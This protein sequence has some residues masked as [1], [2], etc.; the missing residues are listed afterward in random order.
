MSRNSS[1]VVFGSIIAVGATVGFLLKDPA[2]RKPHYVSAKTRIVVTFKDQKFTFTCEDESISPRGSP[3]VEVNFNGTI[4]S[5][6]QFVFEID[7]AHSVAGER[8]SVSGR[9]TPLKQNTGYLQFS[10][11]LNSV[12]AVTVGDI[13]EITPLLQMNEVRLVGET[14]FFLTVKRQ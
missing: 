3:Y 12:M 11:P 8:K 2:V 14:S 6:L 9:F 1:L 10:K 13:V 4:G 7:R 5:D